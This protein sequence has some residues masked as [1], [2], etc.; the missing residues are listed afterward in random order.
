MNNNKV[1]FKETWEET[2]EAV[3]PIILAIGCLVLGLFFGASI[4]TPLLSYDD[5]A[6]VQFTAE[7]GWALAVS[8]FVFTEIFF[9]LI[10][11]CMKEDHEDDISVGAII[12]TKILCM[13]WASLVAYAGWGLYCAGKALI[14]F[15]EYILMG[16]GVLALFV[17]LNIGIAK[18]MYRGNKK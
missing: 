5:E 16:A 18:K 7:I 15:M 1:T 6:T 11:K 8:F 9:V 17:I 12:Y 14:P 2:S 13:C 4:F 3:W 10:H